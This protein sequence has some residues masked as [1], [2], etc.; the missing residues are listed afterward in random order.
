MAWKLANKENRKEIRKLGNRG[1]DKTTKETAMKQANKSNKEKRGR[2]L[3]VWQGG[4][5]AVKVPVHQKFSKFHKLE[6]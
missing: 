5:T 2:G 6:Y 4:A 3:W 1:G